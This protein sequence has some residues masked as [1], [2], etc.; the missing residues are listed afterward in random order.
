MVYLEA[1][2]SS[3]G[4]FWHAEIAGDTVTIK[5]GKVGTAGVTQVKTLASD[6]AAQT[7]LDKQE[8]SKMKKGYYAAASG[9]GGGAPAAK[10]AKPAAKKAPAKKAPAKKK[11]QAPTKAPAKAKAP[12]KK[13]K[14]A[15]ATSVPASPGKSQ[16]VTLA[17]HAA[18]SN[19]IEVDKGMA[20]HD[21]KL[22]SNAEVGGRGGGG[23]D[24]MWVIWCGV[25]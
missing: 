19:N 16:R 23:G 11:A 9:G 14:A 3:G 4:K 12:A 24:V 5:Y 7:Y 25:K 8:A 2:S 17:G 21:A 15:S 13:R 10:R 6:A 20:G 22:Y 1:P 18:G